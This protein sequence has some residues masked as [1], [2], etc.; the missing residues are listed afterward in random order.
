MAG[1][2]IDTGTDHLQAH[3]EDRVAVLP[4]N[5]PE[6]RNALSD[7]LSPA[8][9]RLF[10]RLHDAEGVRA[11]LGKGRKDERG[12]FTLGAGLKKDQIDKVVDVVGGGAG[13]WTA[14]SES[15]APP[16]DDEEYR[17]GKELF[18]HRPDGAAAWALSSSPPLRR[19]RRPVPRGR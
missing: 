9:R 3:V 12:D 4:M 19:R 10:A 14:L 7:T 18:P 11:L 6:R 17:L 8:M 2:T 16:T 13:A 1:R 5:R 15:E